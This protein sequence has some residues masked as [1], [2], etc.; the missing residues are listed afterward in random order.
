MNSEK[1]QRHKRRTYWPDSLS[2]NPW[3]AWAHLQIGE[4]LMDHSTNYLLQQSESSAQTG[5]WAD[6]QENFLIQEEEL[7]PS[8]WKC[9]VVRKC[10]QL[11]AE[12]SAEVPGCNRDS[13]LAL[14]KEAPVRANLLLFLCWDCTH[15]SSKGSWWPPSHWSFAKLFKGGLFFWP[16]LQALVWHITRALLSGFLSRGEACW[17]SVLSSSS[18]IRQSF[19]LSWA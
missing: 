5:A 14:T 12:Q 6:N 10:L 19:G 7:S 13:A 1:D 8:S 18:L 3:A 11:P 17:R 4:A 16:S 9:L 2:Q 15:C